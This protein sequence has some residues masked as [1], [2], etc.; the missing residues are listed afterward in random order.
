[1]QNANHV[2]P[3][4]ASLFRPGKIGTMTVRNRFVQAPIY[5][6]FASVWGEADEKMIEYTGLVRGAA[7]A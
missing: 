5:T 4:L 1:M 3:D 2:S 6:L 7:L